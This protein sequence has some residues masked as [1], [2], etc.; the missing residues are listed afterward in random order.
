VARRAQLHQP[1]LDG[2]SLWDNGRYA[3]PKGAALALNTWYKL[4][5]SRLSATNS[6][7]VLQAAEN[8]PGAT[9]AEL[10]AASGVQRNTLNALLARLVKSGELRTEALPTGATGYVLARAQPPASPSAPAA[11]GDAA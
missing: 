6:S 3:L 1:R 9:S 7:V 11:A 10:A 4:K 2:D 5:C 8:R